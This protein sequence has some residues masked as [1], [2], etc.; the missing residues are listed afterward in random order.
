MR[1]RAGDWWELKIPVLVAEAGA[2]AVI[3]GLPG[4]F[5][6]RLAALV[7]S[8]AAFAAAAHVVNDSFDIDAD[9]QAGKPNTMAGVPGPWRLLL[10]FALVAFGAAPWLV[11]GLGGAGWAVLIVIVVS[12]VAYSAPPM[13]L[14]SRG[15]WGL[16]GDVVM[17][18][19]APN[20]F[21]VVAFAG[22]VGDLSVAGRWFAA[23]L[24]LWSAAVGLRDIV[25]HQLDDLHNDRR[26][27]T[28]TWTVHHGP[29]RAERLLAA[30]Y[31]VEV[32]SFF[33]LALVVSSQSEVAG[34]LALGGVL[35]A[36]VAHLSGLWAAPLRAR[37]CDPTA[38]GALVLSASIWSPLVV[39]VA[40]AVEDLRSLLV[41]ALLLAAMP[42]LGR[43]QVTGLVMR[44][45]L[46]GK[47]VGRGLRGEPLRQSR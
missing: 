13:R 8:A 11:V 12:P 2:V 17:E 26:S 33:G 23:T 18:R 41:L 44:L 4:D 6:V 42:R 24:A 25:V 31:P 15:A 43:R 20:A 7:L 22:G 45:R 28:P 37:P 29:D 34:V 46:I 40:L 3:E 36:V 30:A 10:W 32:G 1:L 5:F 21:V 19:L 38:T 27:A 39:L 9:A 35:T 14:K 47:V 16:V